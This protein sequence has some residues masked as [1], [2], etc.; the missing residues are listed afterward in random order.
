MDLILRPGGR[1]IVEGDSKLARAFAESNASGLGALLVESCEGAAADFWRGFVREFFTELCRVSPDSS[2]WKPIPAPSRNELAVRVAEAPPAEGMEYLSID[3]LTKIWAELDSWARVESAK[4][5]G[6]LDAWLPKFDPLWRL[7]GRV[8]FHLAENR[9]SAEFPFAFLATYTH[10]LSAQANLQHLPLGKAVK[11]FAGK[12]DTRVLR[13]L[14]EPIRDASD[15]SEFVQQLLESKRVFRALAWTPEEAWD[16]LNAVPDLEESGIVARVPDWWESKRPSR[17]KVE[18]EIDAQDSSVGLASLLKFNVDVALDGERLTREELEKLLAAAG[19]LI[20]IKGKWVEIDREKLSQALEL[21]QRAQFAAAGGGVPFHEAMRLLAGFQASG[22]ASVVP[23]GFPREWTSISAGSNLAE[24]LRQL[25]DPGKLE[26]I[27]C[28]RALKAKLRPYQQAGLNWLWLMVRSGFGG[29]LADDMGLGKTL[30][31]IATLLKIKQTDED[32]PPSLLV[33]P[34]SLIGN[35]RAEIERFAPSLSVYFAHPSQVERR[36]LLARK[37]F[38]PFDAVITTYSMLGR[39]PSIAGAAWNVLVLDEA[40]AIKNPTTDQ[41][42]VVKKLKSRARIALTGTPIENSVTDLW[43]IFDFL[44]PGLLGNASKFKESVKLMRDGGFAPLRRLVRPWILRRLKTDKSVISDLPDKTEVRANCF[45]TK[46]QAGYYESTVKQLAA[47]LKRPDMS[48]IER[49]GLVLTTLMRL[50][51]ICNHTAMWTGSGNYEPQHSGK[52]KRLGEIAA[53]IAARGEKVLVFT[54]FREMTGPLT[55]FLGQKFSR[56][57]LT[58]HGGTAVGRRADLVE[59]FQDPAGPPA[60]VISL[61]A[62]GTG[63]NLTAASHVVHFDRWWN[64]AVE[65]QA[66]D[67]AYRIGQHRNVLVHKFVCVGTIEEKIDRMISE[68]RQLANEIICEG[69]EQLLTEMSDAELLGLVELDA[70]AVLD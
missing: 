34:A 1:L 55:E 16:F 68:K 9:R 56:S 63:L 53:E 38:E 59:R 11:E 27:E 10:K 40:Q 6:G 7:V 62:G 19:N 50:K 67:R 45:L 58:L 12:K 69:A 21:W 52:F 48:P 14:L 60:F 28:G 39:L 66:T 57:V 32:L 35:W 65:D 17:P 15:R 36:Q 51:Q 22:A 43:S 47:D 4:C 25:R 33:V 41:T 24:F 37:S 30:Q 49:R 8:T 13:T 20:S 23:A 42:L 3:L 2:D 64:P 44:N 29:C 46:A 31:V 70:T 54:Q 26:N 18:V 61:K 5:E